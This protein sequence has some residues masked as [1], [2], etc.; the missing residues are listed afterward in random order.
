MVLCRDGQKESGKLRER[1]GSGR[2]VKTFFPFHSRRL[3]G[4]DIRHC[5]SCGPQLM[6]RLSLCSLSSQPCA[7]PTGNDSGVTV[8]GNCAQ[9]SISY[10]IVAVKR[11]QSSSLGKLFHPVHCAT[12]FPFCLL[13]WPMAS[14]LEREVVYRA[15]SFL[16]QWPRRSPA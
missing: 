6:K 2:E 13:G 3:S 14:S 4:G 11:Y 10:V 5:P 15:V 7:D 16:L 9:K 8:I 1:K 12:W